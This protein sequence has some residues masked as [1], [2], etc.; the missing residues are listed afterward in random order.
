MLHG[1]MSPPYKRLYSSQTPQYQGPDSD[2]C[3]SPAAGNEGALCVIGNTQ[4]IKTMPE[5]ADIYDLNYLKLLL[6]NVWEA[7]QLILFE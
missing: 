3:L 2:V 1:S 6:P 4:A 7:E 5:L